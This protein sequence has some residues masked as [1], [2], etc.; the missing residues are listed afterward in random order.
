MELMENLPVP[1]CPRAAGLFWLLPGNPQPLEP[2]GPQ[3]EVRGWEAPML[4]RW[5]LKWLDQAGS[6]CTSRRSG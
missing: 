3:A 4:F 1:I 6:L 5:L 2:Q